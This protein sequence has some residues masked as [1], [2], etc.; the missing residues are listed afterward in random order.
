MGRTKKPAAACPNE[1][2]D[3]SPCGHGCCDFAT[4]ARRQEQVS[5][6]DL[7]EASNPGDALRT[8]YVLI[9]YESVQPEAL[10]KLDQEHFKI[11]VF[12]GANQA[13]VTF[14]A[15]SA[16][17]RL[18]AKAE[19]IKISGNGPNALDFHIA[20]Y[21]GRLAAQEPDAYFHIISK[22][23]GFDPLIQHLKTK[24][25]FAARSGDIA[26]IPLSR[27]ANLKSPAER[28]GVVVDKLQRLGA[29]PGS[30]KTL[31]STINAI[32]Q[33]QLAEQEVSLLVK[34]L[35]EKGMVNIE[36]TKVSYA[37]P[38]PGS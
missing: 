8:N 23:T 12:V 27:A 4:R 31:F 22:D 35:Q 10:S 25:I 37:L 2:L 36:G 15:A 19:Y 28:F 13:K 18:G 33:K 9:D 26:D 32:F 1:N 24:E 29:K 14:E 20:F 21:I 11:L 16:L 3:S 30:L 5:R 38:T 17:Q 34:E 7:L 6:A